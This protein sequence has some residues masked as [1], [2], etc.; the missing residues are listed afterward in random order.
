MGGGKSRGVRGF[1][2]AC[3]LAA[4][5]RGRPDYPSFER[6]YLL[7]WIAGMCSLMGLPR[8][9][10]ERS[11]LLAQEAEAWITRRVDA[12]FPG[13]VA[14]IRQLHAQGYPLC[15]ASGESSTQLAGYLSC[16]GVRACFGRLYGPDL[17]DTFKTSPAYY[18]RLLADAAIP[19]TAAV[20]VDD[21]LDALAWAAEV[22]ACPV[23][24][25]APASAVGAPRWQ[26]TSLADLPAL[27][28]QLEGTTA[29]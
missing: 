6:A 22:G 9:S 13:A 2:R 14:A 21:S 25:G 18:A 15:T 17:I 11:L 7:D 8:P 5:H 4:S 12:A 20:I 23:Y 27:L 26:I 10:E 16:M 19:P 24:V 29:Q 3:C 28:A 1:H